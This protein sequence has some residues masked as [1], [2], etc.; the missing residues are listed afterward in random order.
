MLP[1]G[2]N[3]WPTGVYNRRMH[4]EFPYVTWVVDGNQPEVRSI[5]HD[6]PAHERAA[7]PHRITTTWT[8]DAQ[9]NGLPVAGGLDQIHKVE[10]RF[11]SQIAP[12]GGLFVGHVIGAGRVT[13]TCYARSAAESTISVRVGL[14]SKKVLEVTSHLDPDWAF[15]RDELEPS[16]MRI[17]WN[18]IRP[19][20]DD[21]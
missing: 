13:V 11:V 14:L 12:I 16:K 5:I 9:A 1:I 17:A 19:T 3:S 21:S 8:Y 6:I 4:D 7:R 10:D 18:K 20:G 15:Y 2:C